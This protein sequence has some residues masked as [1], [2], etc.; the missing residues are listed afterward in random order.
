[1]ATLGPGCG[2]AGTRRPQN[3]EPGAMTWS[4]LTVCFSLSPYAAILSEVI[5]TGRT[6]G[7]ARVTNRMTIDTA[8]DVKAIANLAVCGTHVC[9]GVPGHGVSTVLLHMGDGRTLLG[10]FYHMVNGKNAVCSHATV[11]TQLTDWEIV[12]KRGA[13]GTV[14]RRPDKAGFG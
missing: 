12:D 13:A 7:H 6:A 2:T 14:R 8:L 11:L 3:S 4:A 10:L 9:P 1:M 5:A